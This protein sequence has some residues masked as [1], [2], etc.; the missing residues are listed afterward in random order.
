MKPIHQILLSLSLC[1]PL[2]LWAEA[3]P[4]AAHVVVQGYGEVE[5]LPDRA[6]LRL[7]IVETRDTVTAAKSDVDRRVATVLAAARG[8][9]IA[10]TAIRA[11]QIRIRPDY[12][13]ENGKRVLRGQQVTRE[14]DI[15][16]DELSRYGALV[17]ALA[18]AGISELGEVQFTVSNRDLLVE[19]ALLA[20][21]ADGRQR[22]AL[23]ATNLGR[24]L[25]KAYRVDA[26][27]AQAQPRPMPAMM[28]EAKVGA[29]A[30]ML[31]GKETVSAQLSLV[32]L[33]D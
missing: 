13:W 26:S 15:Q 12:S 1:F 21:L 4:D 14:V 7:Q 33:L 3:L 32:F 5:A 30:P 2:P 18:A 24:Q 8:Q 17:D 9:G 19:Q 11:S 25:G 22:A 28:M 29:D 20:A 6:E 23:L 16:L 31:I 10:D 27:S